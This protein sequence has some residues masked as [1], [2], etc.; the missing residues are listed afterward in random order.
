MR[1]TEQQLISAFSKYIVNN[2]PMTKYQVREMRQK[3]NNAAI[4]L[5]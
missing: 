3:L 4:A 2:Y 5:C 1:A